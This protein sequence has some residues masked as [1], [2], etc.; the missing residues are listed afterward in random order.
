[1]AKRSAEK[2]IDEAFFDALQGHGFTRLPGE[3]LSFVRGHQDGSRWH[4]D[5]ELRSY[6]RGF[7]VTLQDVSL[8]AP[9][10][11]QLLEEFRGLRAYVFDTGDPISLE[12]TVADA[13]ADLHLYGLP[14][15]AGAPV[16]TVATE[17]VKQ[18][19]NDWAYQ[20]AVGLARAKF[21]KGEYAEAVTAFEQ[22]QSFRPLDP[23]DEK[24]RSLAERKAR[25]HGS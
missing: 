5:V 21:K 25:P 17:A 6:L 9:V 2:V 12:T 16:A 22:A 11:R 7:G 4:L 18:A 19:T 1:V 3:R 20:Q 8:G 14:W 23:I 13:L 10:R 24:Y 15:F